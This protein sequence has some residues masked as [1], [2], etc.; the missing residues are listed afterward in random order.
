MRRNEVWGILL[1]LLAAAARADNPRV[2]LELREARLPDVVAQLARAAD[3]KIDLFAAN[4]MEKT[5]S[6]QWSDAPL[7]RALREVSARFGMQCRKNSG[8]YAL[9]S[10]PNPPARPRPT[11]LTE[12]NGVR[13]YARGVTLDD[14]RTRNFAGENV[15]PS[16]TRLQLQLMVEMGDGDG[17]AVAGLENVTARDDQ[18]NI[19]TAEPTRSYGGSYYGTQYPDEWSGTLSL[20]APHPRARSLLTVEGDLMVYRTMKRFQV[21]IPVPPTERSVRRQ[22]GDWLIVVSQY[23]LAPKQ[24]EDDDAGLPALFARPPQAGASMRVRIYY[25]VR[26]A[27]AARG[28]WGM[29]P[30]LVDSRGRAYAPILSGGA[31]AGNGELTLTDAHLVFPVVENPPARLVWDLV[32]RGQPSRLLSFR[33]EDIPL[34]APAPFVPRT[35]PPPSAARVTLGPEH[36][37]AQRGGGLLLSRVRVG[38]RPATGGRLQVGLAPKTPAG[39]GPVRW[40]ELELDLDGTATLSEIRPGAYRLVRSYRSEDGKS[41]AGPGVWK[42]GRVEITVAAGKSSEPPPLRWTTTTGTPAAPPAPRAPR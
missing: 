27:V 41:P 32:E 6:F 38:D 21:E 36:P 24:G 33:L 31:G 12:K 35:T 19:V 17:D 34:P 10:V 20:S 25:P 28:G 13:I 9:Y 40:T 29:Y 1:V 15:P 4:E 37:Y 23:E 14:R 8:G 3:T 18:G 26:T 2:T 11:G 16:D 7:S 39:W 42:D 30:T 22:A 5:G